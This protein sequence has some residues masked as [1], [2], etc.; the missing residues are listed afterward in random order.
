M[1]FQLIFETILNLAHFDLLLM[2]IIGVVAGLCFGALPGLSSI[3]GMAIVL[4]FTFGMDPLAAMLIYAGII[5]VSPLGGSIPAILLN[6]PGTAPNAA[7]CFDGFPMTQNGEGSR[8]IAVSSMSCMIG[9]IFGVVVLIVLLKFVIP[10][11]LAFRAPE[12]FW[13]IIFGLMVISIV[14]KGSV[15]KR[16]FYCRNRNSF[17][18]HRN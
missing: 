15:L 7:S 8:A 11:I 1:T 4:P 6:T 14:V 9:T 3:T 10:I 2:L 17:V 16:A 18:V 13:L 5:S 12:M